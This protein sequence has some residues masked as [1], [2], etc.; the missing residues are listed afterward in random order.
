[1][2]LPFEKLS[3]SQ[4]QTE[5]TS[6]KVNL[7]HL[8]PTLKDLGPVLKREL[9]GVKILP[10]LL[11]NNPLCDL[12]QLGLAKYEITM[13]ECMHDIAHHIDN[14]LLEL[15]NHLKFDDKIKINE[16]LDALNAE[17]EK[18]RCCDRRKILLLLTKNLH[19]KIDGDVHRLL[20]TLSEIQRILYLG[21]DF[22]HLRKF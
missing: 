20:R 5:L 19:Y 22:R 12:N 14:I 21:D 4:L 15:P 17:K 7:K 11:L 9:P 6:R 16:M 18:K 13:V 1:M 2:T 8:K 10:I 3:I